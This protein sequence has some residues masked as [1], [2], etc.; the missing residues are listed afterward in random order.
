MGRRA[1]R[2]KTRK[3]K[4]RLRR[5][6]IKRKIVEGAQHGEKPTKTARRVAMDYHLPR[7]LA[8]EIVRC[9]VE[10]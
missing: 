7:D 10:R 2:K 5:A 4:E 3:V 9:E 1:G 6:E 8:V